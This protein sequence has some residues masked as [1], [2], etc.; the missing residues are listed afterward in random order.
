MPGC[1]YV[2]PACVFGF[3]LFAQGAPAFWIDLCGRSRSFALDAQPG[4]LFGSGSD[5]PPPSCCVAAF[6]QEATS[7]HLQQILLVKQCF[8]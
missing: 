5:P 8:P 6:V 7:I 2:I 3:V 1:G 4:A